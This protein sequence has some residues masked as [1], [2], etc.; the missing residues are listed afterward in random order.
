MIIRATQKKMMS[1]PVTSTDEGRKLRSSFVSSGQPSVEWHHSA[2]ENQVSSTSS[3]WT[4][5]AGSRPSFAAACARAVGRGARDVDV[6]VL[7]VPRGDAVAPP[8]LARDAPVL[9]VVDPVQVRR[10]PLLR[11]ELHAAALAGVPAG[12]AVAD[13]GQAEVLDGAAGEMRMR[14]RRRR[15]HRDEPLVGQH[16]LDDFLRAAA[17]RDD[18][19]VR[20]LADQQALG[21]EIGEH[22]L[23]RRVAVEAAVLR[24]RIVVDGRVEI[25]DGD[26][27]QA[28]PLSDLP[29]VEVVRRRDLHAAGAERLVDVR[30]GDHR[31]RAPG[32]RQRDLPADQRRVPVVVGVHRDRDVAEHRLRSGR[33]DDDRVDP[34]A[35]AI[36]ER[37]AQ[38]P[39]L[40]LLL[41]ALDLEIRHRGAE[42]RVPVHQALA[43][44]D[45]PV[46]VQADE[47]LPHRRGK[48][49]VHREA[50]ARPV[51]RRAEPPHLVRDGRAGVLL[52]RPDALGELLAAEIAPAL[53]LRLQLLLDD[54]L[55]RNAG[56][57]GAELP[58]RVVAAHPVVADQHVHQRH[59]ER[60]PH[61]QR[62]GDVRRRKLDAEGARAGRAVGLEVALR[63]PARIPLRFD[64]VGFEALGEFHGGACR[65]RGGVPAK[66]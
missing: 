13:G 60:V 53:A 34:V 52:P 18:H 61:V 46:F 38:L 12:E 59:L 7:V 36:G 4:N 26:R 15:A 27:R 57:I 10:Q 29:V 49:L 16:R 45:E 22:R 8:Q 35:C 56:V 21:R 41:L 66:A 2:D 39:D 58:E 25:Q 1:K 11:H 24:R 3:S 20:L 6:A 42:R 9:D 31:N 54:D 17:A 32:Q 63:F 47:G 65:P 30:V 14:G 51:A 64:G 23:A 19:P 43:A 55:R 44:I 5:D 62:A 33:R 50:L 40:P 37:I 28:V 48:P